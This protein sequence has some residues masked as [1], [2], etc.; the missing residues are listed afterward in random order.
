[1][2]EKSEIERKIVK[3]SLKNLREEEQLEIHFFW[4]REP[5]IDLDGEVIKL[6]SRGRK[7]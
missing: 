4:N 5:V 2:S 1:M 7:P 3:L 6:F